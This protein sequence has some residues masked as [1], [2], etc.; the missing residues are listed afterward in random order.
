MVLKI[1]FCDE[2][3]EM[4]VVPP[5]YDEFLQF[6]GNLFGLQEIDK[7]TFEFTYDNNKYFLLDHNNYQALYN[8][9]KNAKVY[10]YFDKEES[11]YYKEHQNEIKEEFQEIDMDLSNKEKQEN[12]II[13]EKQENNIIEENQENNVNEEKLDNNI[14][15]E[16]YISEEKEEKDEK[17]EKEEFSSNEIKLPEITKDMVIA[18][19]IK[20][21][22]E[23]RQQSKI[24]LDKERKEKEKK[25]KE[26][27][28][29]E[30]ERKKK[31]E[32]K[33]KKKDF[34]G[35][36]GDL[37][38]N[39]VESF[40]NELINES[41]IKL[42]QIITESQIQFKNQNL[43]KENAKEIH[44]LEEHPNVVCSKC[45]KPIIGN[46]YCCVECDNANFCD[47]CEEEIGFEHGHPLYKFKL[48]IEEIKN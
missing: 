2:E 38:N 10:I 3:R 40:K 12:N 33:P 45:E 22:K 14:I 44:S 25:E 19:I 41:K 6:L 1:Y 31:E 24:Q 15:N 48:R 23:R 21:V 43:E 18:S 35:E 36:I 37:I 11:N 27:R 46:R 17:D 13:E 4:D 42:N 47:K 30:K 8:D 9:N 16:N 20:Q 28:R 5:K 32:K 7:F 29:K 39:R 26:E 34:A